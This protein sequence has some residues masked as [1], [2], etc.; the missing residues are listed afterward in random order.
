MSSFITD[1]NNLL[2]LLSKRKEIEIQDYYII[3]LIHSI[4]TKIDEEDIKSDII[5]NSYILKSYIDDCN[6]KLISYNGIVYTSNKKDDNKYIS[7]YLTNLNI[8]LNDFN[9]FNK[10]K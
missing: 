10:N 9:E 1:I 2:N 7:N 5:I 3:M 6:N 4:F 8:L